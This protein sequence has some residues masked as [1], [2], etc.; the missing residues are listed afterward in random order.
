MFHLDCRKIGRHITKIPQQSTVHGYRGESVASETS[1]NFFKVIF[2][3][4]FILKI[5]E[6]LLIFW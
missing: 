4:E 6:C 5:C 3:R 2:V 1:A